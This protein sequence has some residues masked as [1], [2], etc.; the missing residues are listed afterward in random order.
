LRLSENLDLNHWEYVMNTAKKGNAN[1][2][3]ALA[4]SAVLAAGA[5]FYLN[6]TGKDDGEVSQAA[7]AAVSTLADATH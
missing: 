7:P 4:I 2:M 1:L 6:V 5:A 3:I